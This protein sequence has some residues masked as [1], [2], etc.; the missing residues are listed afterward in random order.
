VAE[1]VGIKI[2]DIRLGP[3]TND[4]PSANFNKHYITLHVFAEYDE[5]EVTLCEPD[6][7]EE[8]KWVSIEELKKTHNLFQ[9]IQNLIATGAI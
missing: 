8:W 9:P 6:K 3:Y 2:R 1:E 4:L 5:G 7:C